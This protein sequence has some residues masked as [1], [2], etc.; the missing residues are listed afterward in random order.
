MAQDWDVTNY[1]E[2]TE[3]KAVEKVNYGV[4]VVSRCVIVYYG[5]GDLLRS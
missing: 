5:D 3:A 2:Q 4:P 1:D